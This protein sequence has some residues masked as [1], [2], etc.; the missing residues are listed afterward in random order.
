MAGKTGATCSPAAPLSRPPNAWRRAKKGFEQAKRPGKHKRSTR[1][2]REEHKRPIRYP[3]AIPWLA[4][5]LCLA[6]AW[7]VQGLR[8]GL[9]ASS[10]F[11]ILLRNWICKLPNSRLLHNPHC[12]HLGTSACVSSMISPLRGVLASFLILHSPHGTLDNP[13]TC[14]GT[15]EP[16]QTP[17]FDQPSSSRPLSCGIAAAE[18]FRSGADLRP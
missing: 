12:R 16:P 17:V 1:A 5:V 11:I 4:P 9:L 13:W 2:T 15:V 10:A 6:C 7:P 3:P 8:V 14:P 18:R